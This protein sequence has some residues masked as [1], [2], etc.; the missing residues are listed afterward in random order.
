[1]NES[2]SLII[3]KN[4][5]PF[6]HL[7]RTIFLWNKNNCTKNIVTCMLHQEVA[8]TGNHSYLY[9]YIIWHTDNTKGY[10]STVQTHEWGEIEGENGLIWF[11]ILKKHPLGN[12]EWSKMMAKSLG[13]PYILGQNVSLSLA[14]TITNT[15]GPLLNSLKLVHSWSLSS[16]WM[17]SFKM[18]SAQK[19]KPL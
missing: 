17:S 6:S 3:G 15:V 4:K 8:F 11:L 10:N 14:T 18:L 9:S 16:K 12:K 19:Q 7:I 2:L 13:L 5:K 1:M